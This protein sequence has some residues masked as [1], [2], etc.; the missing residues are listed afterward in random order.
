MQKVPGRHGTGLRDVCGGAWERKRERERERC[1]FGSLSVGECAVGK[2]TSKDTSS[3]GLSKE[4]GTESA[5]KRVRS[6]N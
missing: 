6:G 5:H 2:I 3:T 1:R 4:F